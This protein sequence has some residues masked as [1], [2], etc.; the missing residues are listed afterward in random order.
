MLK[1][2][3][4]L[5]NRIIRGGEVGI[6]ARIATWLEYC[7]FE[8]GIKSSPHSLNLNLRGLEILGELNRSGICVIPNYWAREQCVLACAEVDRVI[9]QYPDYV[10]PSAKADARV[11]GADSASELISEFNK[12][13]ELIALATAYNKEPTVAPFTLAARMPYSEGNN[14]SGEGWHR[15]AFLRQFKAIIYLSDVSLS[16]G[17][18]QMLRDSHSLHQILHDMKLA[19]LSYKQTRFDDQIVNKLLDQDPCRLMTYVGLAGT[20][21][22][23]DTS[24]IHRGMPIQMGTRY[25]LTNYYYPEVRVDKNMYKKFKVL[26]KL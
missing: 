7:A 6:L 20:L 2:I 14:G 11:Y 4:R 24:V 3:N 10:H 23:V 25:A 13:P 16:S 17:P 18:F 15:D 19:G 22:L 8:V 5:L 21:I 9:E 26:P 1:Y 12:N